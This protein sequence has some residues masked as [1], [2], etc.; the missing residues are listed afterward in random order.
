MSQPHAPV[1]LRNLEMIRGIGILIVVAHHLPHPEHAGFT[2]VSQSLWFIVDL[3]FVQSGFLITSQL[4]GQMG[5]DGRVA[6]GSF[7]AKRAFRILPLYF[8][9]LGLV[10]AFDPRA[11]SFAPWAHM[12][13]VQN[14]APGL[15][16]HTFLNS[17]SLC[18]EEH[19]YIA[20]PLLI[21]AGS[22]LPKRARLR[23][24]ALAA[25]ALLIA[26]PLMRHDAWQERV[27]PLVGVKRF[28][29]FHTW[30]YFRTH[31]RLEALVL[32]TAL[33]WV[34]VQHPALLRRVVERWS[35]HCAILAAALYVV[36]FGVLADRAGRAGA[37]WGMS[38][39][40]IICLL[41]TIAALRRTDALP[42]R[43]MRATLYLGALSFP[44]YLIHPLVIAWTRAVI[45]PRLSLGRPWVLVV[46]VVLTLAASWLLHHAVEKPALRLR[47]RILR[48]TAA[49]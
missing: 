28:D 31:L 20:L 33:G 23:C 12:V 15:F 10:A 40:A 6:L 2:A 30:I 48:E 34:S 41:I 38:Y 39:G 46:M 26:L 17:W 16:H 49:P 19:F 27:A 5:R 37:T 11:L 21:I 4:F 9:C 7:W 25:I 42:A 22:L 35:T 8:V 1:R 47:R 29:E 44:L 14:Y 36:G 43:A 13:L 3:F 32:G 18:V 24:A 45:E